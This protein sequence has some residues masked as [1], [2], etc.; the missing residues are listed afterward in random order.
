MEGPLWRKTLLRAVPKLRILATSREPLRAEGEVT[1]RLAG[2][3]APQGTAEIADLRSASQYP[4]IELFV[5]RAVAGGDDISLLDADVPLISQICRQLDGIPLAIELAAARIGFLGIAGIAKHLE[6]RFEILAEGRR[7]ALPRHRT[8]RAALNWSFES[9][10]ENEQMLLTR[11]AVFRSTFS[12][13]GAQAVASGQAETAIELLSNLVAKSLV[14]VDQAAT[15]VRYR[16]LETTRAFAEEK[17]RASADAATVWRQ[18]A[19]Y[20]LQLFSRGAASEVEPPMQRLKVY[21]QRVDDVRNALEWSFSASGDPR[22]GVKMIIDS[23]PMWLRLSL[24]SEYTAIV[25]NAADRLAEDPDLNH[26][27]LMWLYAQLH[28]VHFHAVGISPKK[29]RMLQTALDLAQSEG[30]YSCQLFCL[31]ALF[32]TRLTQARYQTALDYALQFAAIA[33]QVPD[34]MQ[35]AMGHRIVALGQW[36]S[37]DLKAANVHGEVAL[38]A[39]DETATSPINLTLIYKHG[40]TSRG[41]FSNLQ[42]LSGHPEQAL[43]MASEAVDAGLASEDFA[44]LSYSLA[45][46]IVP[47]AF[48]VGDYELAG[49]RTSQL[50][51][52]ARANDFGFWLFWGRSYECARRRLQERKRDANDFIEANAGVLSGVHRH[53][54]ATILEDIAVD[55]TAEEAGSEQPHW[56]LAELLRREAVRSQR[57]DARPEAERLLARSLR[58]ARDQGALAWELRSATTLA[59]LR[60]TEGRETEAVAILRPVFEQFTEGFETQDLRKAADLLDRTD[61]HH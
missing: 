50:L 43:Q 19:E 47:L 13:E 16:L 23:A 51:D 14:V 32:G 5:E 12:I 41:N 6:S 30:D 11:L 38:R 53:I 34:P 8:M 10:S 39:T 4:A 20:L 55:L 56:C 33:P 29:E 42:W 3:D 61:P 17:L 49:E 46:T 25:E 31:W 22:I 18:H 9:L 36:R 58:V 40:V 15:A 37:G 1:V 24:L 21:R 35:L 54:L 28:T 45:Q 27:E 60:S 59:E 7:T 48:W 26:R 44:G 52:L 57:A 2:L